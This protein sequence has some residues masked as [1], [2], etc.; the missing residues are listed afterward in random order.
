MM[1]GICKIPDTIVHPKVICMFPQNFIFLRHEN[2]FHWSKRTVELFRTCSPINTGIF[3]RLCSARCILPSQSCCTHLLI[4]IH[5]Q[6]WYPEWSNIAPTVT[7]FYTKMFYPFFFGNL[8]DTPI[9]R[10][11]ISCRTC[12]LLFLL[13]AY[14]KSHHLVVPPKAINIYLVSNSSIYCKSTDQCV[15]NFEFPPSY[16]SLAVGFALLSV[17]QMARSA[18]I[19]WYALP[20][21]FFV[22]LYQRFSLSRLM[23]MHYSRRKDNRYLHSREL[24]VSK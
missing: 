22:V 13:Y 1:T 3:K 16:L 8:T 11:L 15:I 2:Y 17:T 18:I 14:D 7:T 19:V 5:N 21:F 6:L 12:I 9:N 4:D 20:T 10:G 24:C 23:I